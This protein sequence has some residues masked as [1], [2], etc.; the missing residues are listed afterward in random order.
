MTSPMDDGLSTE[1]RVTCAEAALGRLYKEYQCL[2]ELEAIDVDKFKERMSQYQW[3]SRY[4]VQDFA[5]GARS[6]VGWLFQKKVFETDYQLPAGF[7]TIM[8]HFE[9]DLCKQ[10]SSRMTASAP[11]TR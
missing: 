6:Y 8:Q 7:T 5:E 9:V 10:L 11:A 3:E 4:R 1:D 2:A